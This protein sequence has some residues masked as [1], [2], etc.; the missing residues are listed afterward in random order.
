[1]AR[2]HCLPRACARPALPARMQLSWSNP[3][4]ALDRPAHYVHP[5]RLI[6]I[7]SLAPPRGLGIVPLAWARVLPGLGD[8]LGWLYPAAGFMNTIN[9]AGSPAGALRASQLV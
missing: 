2:H 6:L 8:S 3:L 4:H 7:W 5:A 9:A 1:M